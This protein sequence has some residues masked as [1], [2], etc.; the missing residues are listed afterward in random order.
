MAAVHTIA[1]VLARRNSGALEARM[2]VRNNVVSWPL[3]LCTRG[4]CLSIT[5]RR[6]CRDDDDVALHTDTTTPTAI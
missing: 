4:G 6:R 5:V 1:A 2:L 3:S